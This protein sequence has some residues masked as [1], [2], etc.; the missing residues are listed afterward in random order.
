M[1]VPVAIALGSNLGDR[2]RHLDFALEQLQ[3]L[4]TGMRVSA[5]R[6]TEP[7]DVPEAQPAYLNAVLVGVTT[8]EAQAL[9]GELLAIEQR[10]HRRRPSPRAPRTLDLDL[11]LYGGEAIEAAGLT[12]P[13][14]RF[15]ERRFVLEPL[16]ELAPEW[17]DPVTGKTVGELLEESRKSTSNLKLQTSNSEPQTPDGRV[18]RSKF[19]V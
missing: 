3:S 9:L 17:I 12:V 6:E 8:L 14:P 15:R 5:I 10:A 1:P 7:F 16:A 2:R 18:R 4:L 19:E 11:I 13:H